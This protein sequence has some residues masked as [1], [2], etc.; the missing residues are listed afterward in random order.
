MKIINNFLVAIALCLFCIFIYSCSDTNS[1]EGIP[2]EYADLPGTLIPR[3]TVWAGDLRLKGQYYV[4][5]GVTLTILKGSTVIWE[6]HNNNIE[7]VGALITMPADRV[8]FEGGPRPSGK[9]I[10]NGTADEPIVFTSSRSTKFAGDWG[11]IIL[12]GEAP[13]NIEGGEGRVEGLPQTI[14]YGG[15]NSMDDS[16]SLRYLRIEYVGFGLQPGSEINGLSLYSVGSE[17]TLE[18]IQVYKSTD[19]GFEWFGGTVNSKYLVSM[20]SNDD[21]FDMDLGWNGKNQFWLGIQADGADNG[22]EGDGNITGNS[23]ETNPVIYNATLAGH[24]PTEGQDINAGM[25]LRNT[26]KGSINNTLIYNFGGAP[27]KLDASTFSNYEQESLQFDSM[28]IYENGEWETN[29]GTAFSDDFIDTD[30]DFFNS[31]PPAFNF[32]PQAVSAAQGISPPDNGF[33]DIEA[34]YIGAFDPDATAPWI[35][36]GVWLRFNDD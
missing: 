1:L 6:Y 7:D 32:T 14:R 29:D 25:N 12:A 13:N 34:D 17:T 36:E 35:Y 2:S 10:A 3:D 4:M 15:D 23:D 18:H 19:D 27:W 8:S 31:S 33:F 26:F 28:L 9:L 20:F 30:P 22:F 5:P 11:G 16:G 21:S 24:G